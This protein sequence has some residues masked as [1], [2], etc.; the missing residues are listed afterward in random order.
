MSNGPT[1]PNTKHQWLEP[2]RW[3]SGL[4]TS[5][6]TV[7]TGET[8]G[9]PVTGFFCGA[10]SSA[11][12][13]LNDTSSSPLTLLLVFATIAAALAI[14]ALR[15]RW[16]PVVSKPLRERRAGGQIIDAAARVYAEYVR[17]LVPV[18]LVAV[19]L[20][21]LAVAAQLALFHSTGLRRA[22]DALED[23]KVESLVALFVGSLAHALAPMLVGAATVLVLRELDRGGN[24]PLRAVLRGLRGELW[25]LVLLG[26]AGLIVVFLLVLTVIGIPYAV[27]KAVDWAFV[28]QVAALEGR[29]GRDAFRGS[30][31]LVRGHWWRVAAITSVLLLLLVVDRAGHRR[32]RHLHHRCPARH[33]QPVRHAPFRPG[34][35]VHVRGGDSPLPRPCRTPRLGGSPPWHASR[36]MIVERSMD[37]RWLSNAYLVADRAGGTAVFVDSGAPVEPLLA[38]VDRLEVHPALLLTTHAHE[39]HVA[40]H[41]LLQGRYGLRVLASPEEE[42]EGAEPLG[43]GETRRRGRPPHRSAANSRPYPRDA[44]VRRRR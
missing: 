28:Q 8:L 42:I 44:L 10:V 9:E 19:P 3:M 26:F 4:R 37:P 11:S 13:L 18:G 12:S 30:R 36:P 21:G 16:R 22:F 29:H 5:S 27:K 43:H 35:S 40:N 14:P 24:A 41:R 7:P 23:A 6:P 20:G 1:G 25:R 38:A 2:F 34:A 33:H 39:D 17:V 32:R 15:T 31:N